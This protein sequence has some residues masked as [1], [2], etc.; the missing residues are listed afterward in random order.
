MEANNAFTDVMDNAGVPNGEINLLIMCM[1]GAVRAVVKDYDERVVN[2]VIISI[3]L[4][5]DLKHKDAFWHYLFYRNGNYVWVL[6]CLSNNFTP[7]ND[8]DFLYLASH[9]SGWFDDGTYRFRKLLVNGPYKKIVSFEERILKIKP[10]DF[11]SSGDPCVKHLVN[12]Y[13][14]IVRP[15]KNDKE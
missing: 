11:K 5:I 13:E 14:K 7:S 10:R 6:G 9:D 2:A 15:K 4:E 12:I 8:D 3:R 1:R